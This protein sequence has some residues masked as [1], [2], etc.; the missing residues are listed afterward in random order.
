M[1]VATTQL[2]TSPRLGPSP[3][4]RGARRRA[5]VDELERQIAKLMPQL[6]IA[7]VHGGD[8]SADGAVINPTVNPRP[9]K[10]YERV[11][12]D[13]AQ[14]LKRIGFAHVETMPDDMQLGER[15]KSRG[16]HFV[17]LNTGGVQGFGA[18]S[19]TPAMLEMFGMPYLGHDP[20]TTSTLDSKHLFKRELA[21]LGLPT[22]PFMTWNLARGPLSPSGNPRF[23]KT[24]GAYRGPFV[25]KPVSGRASL[26][27]LVVDDAAGI[28]DAVAEIHA[29]TE[30]TVM[31]ETYLGGKEYCI[32]ACGLVVA[33]EGRLVRR[34]EPFTFSAVERVLTQDE[35]IF[36]S[37]DQVPITTDRTRVLDAD[38]DHAV[39]RDLHALARSVFEELDLE[40]L[41]R[42]DVR[43]DEE[44]RLFVLE[45]NPKPDLAAPQGARTS[46]VCCGL[47]R[48]EMSYDDLILSL[49]ADRLDILFCQRRSSAGRITE[50][51]G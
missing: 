44:G 37:M 18:M 17:W 13:I 50:L 23:Q 28:P 32:A 41:V 10:S 8:K 20:I 19:H 33:K 47:A 35:R 21:L 25:L 51:V 3:E 38:R 46:L 24:F 29:A 30:N 15:L 42:L 16:I 5:R 43:A 12:Q 22:A 14:S 4:D 11:A 31:I 2:T 7:V 45:A 6:R 36:T 48:H 26:N 9:W 40:T 49:L 39:Y 27:V 1:N 34:N